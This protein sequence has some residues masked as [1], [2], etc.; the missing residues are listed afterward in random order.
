MGDKTMIKKAGDL[1]EF[2]ELDLEDL[3][4]VAGGASMWEK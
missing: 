4:S 2:K 1:R 3:A